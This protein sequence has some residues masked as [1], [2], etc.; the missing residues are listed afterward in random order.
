MS[1]GA[2]DTG[3][4][5]QIGKIQVRG[6]QI[7]TKNT[8]NFE[9]SSARV[10][11]SQS[12]VSAKKTPTQTPSAV[13]KLTESHLN[14]IT[15]LR[16]MAGMLPNT[17]GLMANDGKG[18]LHLQIEEISEVTN[19]DDEKEIQRILFILEGQKLVAPYPEGDFTSR[20][21]HI[22]RE[23]SKALKSIEGALLE[24]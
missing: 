3:S 4:N 22:T 2:E 16:A 5:S 11:G 8:T 10:V 12:V 13:R 15:V 9:S 19:L 1:L 6:A 21:W 23:G 17:E 20:I 24:S 14:Q 7:K 18:D